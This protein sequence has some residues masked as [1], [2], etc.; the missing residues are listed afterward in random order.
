MGRIVYDGVT[1]HQRASGHFHNKRRGYLHRYIWEQ[2]RG[3]VPK[4]YVVHHIDHDPENNHIDNLC[5]MSQSEHMAHHST[6]RAISEEQ[7]RAISESKRQF[8]RDAEGNACSCLMCGA[9]FVSKAA[10]PRK[11][12]SSACT[13]KWRANAFVPERRQ[14][15][16]CR[17]EY[18]AVKRVQRYCGKKCRCAAFGK[19]PPRVPDGGGN[20]RRKVS[21]SADIRTD[22]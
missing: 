8:W 15:E 13:E 1:W 5:V 12:C 10:S 21:E 18:L 22:G 2:A 7:R 20:R 17:A 4:G 16:W 9:T 19:I 11:F 14:C 6:G 3:P